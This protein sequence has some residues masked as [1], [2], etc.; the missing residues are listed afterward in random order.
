M[1]YRAVIAAALMLAPA[2]AQAEK[3]EMTLEERVRK[4]EDQAAIRELI[5][6]YAVRLDAR[7]FDG[8]A[9]LFAKDGVWKNGPVVHQGREAIRSMLSGIYGPTPPGYQNRDSYRIVHN[10]EI[11]TLEGDRATARSKHLTLMRGENEAP[12][13]RLVGIYTDEFIR[14]DGEWKF[15]SRDDTVFMPSAEEWGRQMAELRAA[16]TRD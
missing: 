15:L 11:L 3:Q 7:D 1:F 6:Q 5:L 16:Q 10:I 9:Q 13:P 14:E 2:A 12:T 8:Y 4:I